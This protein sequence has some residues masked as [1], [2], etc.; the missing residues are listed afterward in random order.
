MFRDPPPAPVVASG[1]ARLIE[2]GFERRE[3][4]VARDGFQLLR[5]TLAKKS[6]ED[7]KKAAE[8]GDAEAQYLLGLAYNSGEGVTEDPERTAYWLRRSATRGF[9]RAQFAFGQRLYWGWGGLKPDKKEGF[10]WWL[11]A[12]ENGNAS[13]MLAIGETYLYG[14]EGVPGEDLAQAEKY[15]NQALLLGNLEAETNLGFLYGMKATKAQKAGATKSFEQASEKKLAYFQSAAQKGSS[16]G[17]YQLAYMYRF[18][19]YVKVD[20]QKAIEWYTKSTAA[21]NADAAEALGQ[22]YAYDST[23]LGKAQP[24]EAAKYFRIAIGLRSETAGIELADLIRNGKVKS[25]TRDEAVQLYEQAVSKGALRAAAGLSEVYLKGELVTK[26]L[27]KAEQ[28]GLKALELEKTVKPDSE[29]AYPMYA[30]LAAYNL[31]KLYKEEKLQPPKPQL[32]KDLEARVGPLN[33]GMKHFN[34]PITCG[35]V[36]STFRVSVWDWKLDE[37]PTT[38]QFAWLEKARGCEVGKDVIEAFQKLYKI[39]RDN[40]VSYS[41]LTEYAVKNPKQKK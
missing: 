20:L 26:D 37:P 28:Y 2:T 38:A 13:A 3:Y 34:V 10:E 33:G 1:P 22:L 23:E 6:I 21:G 41:E 9:S 25:K 4:D 18:G 8:G 5:Q 27:K 39:A 19:D 11:V 36:K 24:E 15:Y 31:L 29:D 16:S 7:I 40:N 32:V 17:M 30:R 35:T 14:R 12:A